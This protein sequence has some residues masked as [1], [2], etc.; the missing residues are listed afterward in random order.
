MISW[1]E[2]FLHGLGLRDP[3]MANTS[4]GRKDE[5]HFTA[6]Q[7]EGAC[8]LLRLISQGQISAGESWDGRSFSRSLQGGGQ[9]QPGRWRAAA[10]RPGLS[11][12]KASR[13]TRISGSNR[14]R[15]QA[16]HGDISMRTHPDSPLPDA[17]LP[18]DAY[19]DHHGFIAPK[20][21]FATIR[22][23]VSG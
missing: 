12:Q 18:I 1:P 23:T 8:Q 9:R 21:G 15:R 3:A 11:D 6:R 5:V 17:Q 19:L 14:G 4:G 22:P 2:P 20:R 7:K 13:S 16:R 10:R